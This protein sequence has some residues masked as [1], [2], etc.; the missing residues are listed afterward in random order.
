MYTTVMMIAMAT[1]GGHKHG[2]YSCAS[3]A[4]SCSTCTVAVASS[5]CKKEGLLSRLFHRNKCNGD[6]CSSACNGCASKCSS[7]SACS[8]SCNGHKHKCHGHKHKC[9]G[10]NG[11]A[12]S[13]CAASSGCSAT[14]EKKETKKQELKPAPKA[15][16]G[17]PKKTT[18]TAG[19]AID[20]VSYEMPE[21]TYVSEPI[22]VFARN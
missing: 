13:S 11:C 17:E 5:C 15:G 14:T 22:I 10:C 21:A 6:S 7:A 3:A 12:V 20:T 9:N 16:A 19:D 1:A 2:C 8:S 4:P 18:S